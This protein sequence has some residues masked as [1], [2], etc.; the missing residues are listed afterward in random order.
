MQHAI[1]IVFHA[2]ILV[3]FALLAL[4]IILFLITLASVVLDF[5]IYPLMEY[6]LVCLV[7]L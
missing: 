5:T 2:I 3:L 6:I 4:R 7:I 1:K